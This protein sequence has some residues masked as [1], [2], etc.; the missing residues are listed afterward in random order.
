MSHRAYAVVLL[1]LSSAVFLPRLG[2]AA[3]K[4]TD[5]DTIS[6][7]DEGVALMRDTDA[8]GVADYLDADADG[9]GVPDVF[10]AGDADLRTSPVDTDGDGIPDFQD[11]DSDNDYVPD[12]VEDANG[13]GK[14][15]PGETDARSSD[16]D[17]D[18]LLDGAEDKNSDGLVD[19]G[20]TDPQHPDT[21]GD[22]I[23]DGVDSCPLAA[24]DFDGLRDTDGC[25]EVD[26]D[27]D[28][29][30]DVI[31]LNVNCLNPLAADTDGDGKYDG[32]EDLDRD[33]KVDKG[34]TDPCRADSDGD[35][36]NDGRDLC[37]LEPEDYDGDRDR[38]GCPEDP[39]TVVVYPDSGPPGGDAGVV[40]PHDQDGDGLP[41]V[42][43]QI[44]CTDPANPDTDGD[45]RIDGEEDENHNG[46]V[47]NGETNPCFPNISPRGGGGCSL[48][49]STLP[50]AA[51]LFF[52][53]LAILLVFRRRD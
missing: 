5:G 46:K 29:L 12:A 43:E 40:K 8:D 41:D 20:E 38:D 19:P 34:E 24:E 33:G 31:E 10:E 9:D 14:V 3:M 44:S 21:D 25:P 52:A 16:S 15:D 36:I 22:G 11:V 42:L 18:G 53:A 2:F 6:D 26:A 51:C 35:G 48:G 1:L 4:D 17:N 39:G 27:G 32:V 45:G 28:G 13:N 47:D 37:P 50:S 7:V 23:K 30:S 49:A